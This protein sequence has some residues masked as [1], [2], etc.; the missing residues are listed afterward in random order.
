MASAPARVLWTS[1]VEALPHCYDPRD[2]QLVNN[3]HSYEASKYQM[4]LLA[5][6]LE[7]RQHEKLKTA[8][9]QV[10]LPVRHLLWH[11]GV[12]ITNIARESLRNNWY[13]EVQTQFLF[14]L[15][16]HSPESVSII[17]S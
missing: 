9:G 8:G 1:S 7:A 11:P 17:L 6:T 16:C 4:D 12:V 3:D 2:W 14:Y 5:G 15:V 10:N 13:L